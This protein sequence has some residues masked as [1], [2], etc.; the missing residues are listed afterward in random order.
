MGKTTAKSWRNHEKIV[1]KPQENRRLSTLVY[2]VTRGSPLSY[3]NISSLLYT[4]AEPVESPLKNLRENLPK[5]NLNS[6]KK[7]AMKNAI[8]GVNITVYITVYYSL[9]ER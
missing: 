5:L 4:H 6:I 2:R 9:V 7:F 3:K 8:R 1:R